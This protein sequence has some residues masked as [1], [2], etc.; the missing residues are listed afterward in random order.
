MGSLWRLDHIEHGR[1][2]F[3]FLL[4]AALLFFRYYFG[5]LDGDCRQGAHRIL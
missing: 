3:L 4:F 5:N 1:L 2:V